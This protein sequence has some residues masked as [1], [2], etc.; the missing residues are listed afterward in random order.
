MAYKFSQNMVSSSKYSIKCPYSLTPQ[1]ITIH[2]TA[3]KASAQN[4]I[5]YMISNSSQTS[6]HVAVDEENVIQGIP[7]NR[8]AWHAGK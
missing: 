5:A 8:N 4:E 6:F 7:F 3:N 1:Y 2:D